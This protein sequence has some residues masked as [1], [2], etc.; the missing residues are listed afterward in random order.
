MTIKNNINGWRRLGIVLS[1]LWVAAFT[2]A[3]CLDKTFREHDFIATE[4]KVSRSIQV[5]APGLKE[6]KEA[7][8]V[9]QLGRALKPWE[10]EWN[11]TKTVEVTDRIREVSAWKFLLV[12]LA[13]PAFIWV[14]I[15]AG[16]VVSRW[17][18]AGFRVARKP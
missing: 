6:M 12:A 14:F 11:P 9:R 10:M 1:I 7:E 2:A 3:V 15:E 4:L 18:I 8:K 13:F 17:V 5:A 16:V